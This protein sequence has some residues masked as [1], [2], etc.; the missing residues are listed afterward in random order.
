MEKVNKKIFFNYGANKK[1][2]EYVKD[3]LGSIREWGYFEGKDNINIYYEKY[4]IKNEKGRIV[5]LH[6]FSECLEKYKELIFY[7]T[8]MGY[9]VYGIEHRGHG[10]SGSL[11]KKHNTQVSLDK[12]EYYIEDLKVF[13]EKIVYDKEVNLYLFGHSMGGG[14]A[15]LFLERYNEYFKK[16]ILS[17]PMMEINTGNYNKIVAYLISKIYICIGK[18]DDFLFGQGPF[19]GKCNLEEAATSNM[20]RYENHLNELR[21]D[22]ILQRGGGSFYWINEAIKLTNEIFRKKNINNLNIPILLFQ[23][24]KDTFVK[25]K[26]QNKFCKR[27]NNCKKI[28][29]ENAKHELY[30]ENDDILL[31]YLKEIEEFLK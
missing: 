1:E 31:I 19:D 13:V 28:R 23:A 22:Q 21:K 25:E 24:G 10:R 12:F 27:Y 11:G 29:F 26:A 20:Y 7:F 5:I 6:G 16:A 14:I 4:C 17:T 15:T 9:S 8:Q 18:G 3:I 2:V 30:C